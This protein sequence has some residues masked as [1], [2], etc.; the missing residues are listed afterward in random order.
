MNI[1][2]L[3]V[4]PLMLALAACGGA[5][6]KDDGVAS[7]NGGTASAK[8]T[9]SPSTTMDRAAAALKFAKCM[10]EHGIDMPDP[11]MDGDGMQITLPKGVTPEKAEKAHKACE[12]LMESAVQEGE[13]P[14]AEDYDQ[15]VKFARCMREQG[16]DMPD[17]KPGEPMRMRM[18]GG[19]KEKMDAAHQACEQH[20][21]GNGKVENGSGG[22]KP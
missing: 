22:G 20:A 10:R 18:R 14:S 3:L 1:R 11:K 6:A 17:P 21:P 9:A 15:M 7:A 8:P 16:I 19:S 13:K 5:V 12:H 4:V 2:L